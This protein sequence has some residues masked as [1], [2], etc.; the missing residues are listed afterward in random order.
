MK[1]FIVINAPNNAFVDELVARKVLCICTTSQPQSFYEARVPYV[2]YTPLMASTQGYI[3][4]AEYVGKRLAGGKAQYA[5]DTVYKV[6]NRKFALLYYETTD[7]AYEEGAKFFEQELKQKY[8]VTLALNLAYLGTDVNAVQSQSGP[9]IQKLKDEGINS[10]IFSGDPISPAIFTKEATKQGYQ[11][12][13]IITGSALVDSALFGRTYDPAQWK[14]AF[15]VSFLTAR[16]PAN[17]SDAYVTYNWHRGTNEAPPASNT[18]P[19]AYS[20]I[21]TAFTG[22]HMAG[23]N[24]TPASFAQ[25]MFAYPPSGGGVTLQTMSFGDHGLWPKEVVKTDM[26]AYDDV[27][28]IWWDPQAT[29]DDEVGHPGVGMYRYVAGGKRYNPGEHP[30]TPAAPFVTEGSVV[31]YNEPPPSD[32]APTYPHKHYK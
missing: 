7:R 8:G 11:P 6:Q 14:N 12:E 19:F 28:E 17:K 13:W 26:T 31:V 22:I 15:G 29:G 9:L 4:R 1:A 5:G 30:S 10:L 3:Q 23:P 18:Y 20:P 27:T 25:G 2:G 16:L 21:F 32:K 24:L